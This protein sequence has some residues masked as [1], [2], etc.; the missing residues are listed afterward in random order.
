MEEDWINDPKYAKLMAEKI[1]QAI[2]KI[3]TNCG[4]AVA[5]DQNKDYLKDVISFITHI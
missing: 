3:Y 4:H 5:V 1:P 2:L